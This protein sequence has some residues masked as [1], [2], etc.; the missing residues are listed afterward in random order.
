MPVDFGRVENYF[1]DRGFGFITHT[2]AEANNRH[3]FFHI[4]T[5]KNLNLTM[6]NALDREIQ[7][8]S[9]Y[10]WYRFDNATK[11]E[12]VIEALDVRD[13]TEVERLS[14]IENI[15]KRY[16]DIRVVLSDG[17]EAATED[18]LSESDISALVLARKNS[19]TKKKDLGHQRQSKNEAKH[20]HHNEQG[21]LEENE[22]NSLVIEI[23]SQGFT[24]TKQVSNYIVKKKLGN[25]YP[26]I[27][28]VLE[29][30]LDGHKWN[31][32]GGFPPKIYARL[33]TEIGLSNQKSRAKPGMFT[34][35]KILGR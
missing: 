29:M 9:V 18:L 8:G 27:S 25:K 31:F 35:Y 11:G 13:I 33:C 7:S 26:N 6:A 22:F 19:E 14:F 28:G 16:S 17:V 32:D 24:E 1:S 2:F 4:T 34:S 10:F 23:S 20:S 30:E 21:T 3:V 15:H 12:Q 5:I